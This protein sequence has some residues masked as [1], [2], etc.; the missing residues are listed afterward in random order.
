MRPAGIRS[1]DRAPQRGPRRLLSSPASGREESRAAIRSARGRGRRWRRRG[2]SPASR[3]PRGEE[4]RRLVHRS[5]LRDEQAERVG[6]FGQLR[7]R[8]ENLAE[9][10]LGFGVP[11]LPDEG[12]PEVPDSRV[13]PW[14]SPPRRP[15]A[16]QGMAEGRRGRRPAAVQVHAAAGEEVATGPGWAA[17]VGRGSAETGRTNRDKVSAAAVLCEV[18]E[19]DPGNPGR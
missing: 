1:K 12:P 10:L 19:P 13:H 2:R 11:S 5:R 9:E 4:R 8:G 18:P 6:H 7:V 14:R 15:H 3:P 17:S 16:Q